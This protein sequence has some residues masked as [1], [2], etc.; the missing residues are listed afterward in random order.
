MRTASLGLLCA[1]AGQKDAPPTMPP[2]PLRLMPRWTPGRYRDAKKIIFIRHAEGWHNKDYREK[3]EFMTQGL[4][5]TETYWDARL[6][7]DGWRQSRELA[8][9]M[10]REEPVELV[11]V[12]PLSRAIQTGLIAFP[13]KSSA[14]PP[15][16]ASSLCRERI[17]VHMC[18]RR[19][20][21]AVLEA[22]FP[23]VDFT[24]VAEGDDEMVR[25]PTEREAFRLLV[26]LMVPCLMRGCPVGA[27]GDA[28]IRNELDG[29]ESA[30]AHAAAVA[31]C[32]P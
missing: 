29:G 24:E 25:P 28:S 3:P 31:A 14:G 2:T 16:I 12:S 23:L 15:F 4:G 13:E 11:V 19:R 18:D 6:T 8:Q 1:V 21:R 20:S 22:D 30:R 17:D 10:N 9:K 27:Q 5:E 7:P 26:R 32:A